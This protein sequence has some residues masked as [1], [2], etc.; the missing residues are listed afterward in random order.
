MRHVVNILEPY[1]RTVTIWGSE[2]PSSVEAEILL[3]VR[4]PPYA[5]EK[6]HWSFVGMKL[7]ALSLLSEDPI[8]D[9]HD[10]S[11]VPSSCVD[12]KKPF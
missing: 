10:S 8:S 5:L 4:H 1:Q 6:I 3:Y 7:K 12:S 2:V 9:N 11:I